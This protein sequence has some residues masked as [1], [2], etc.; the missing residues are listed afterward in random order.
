MFRVRF[1]G[2]GG[3]GMK[4]A[5]HILGSAFFHE[6]FEVQDAP[7]YGAERRGAP[8]FAYVRAARG[9]INERGIIRC[10]DLVIVADE[11]LV[12]V[13]AAEVLANF[14]PHTTLL[15]N[16]AESAETWRGRLNLSS[17]IICLPLA[18]AAEQAELPYMGVACAG[19]AARLTGVIGRDALEETIAG[20]LGHLG[21][22]V[23]AENLK[24]ALAAFDAMADHEGCVAEGEERLAATA[25]GADWIEMP[26]DSSEQATPAIHAGATSVEVRTGLW[27]VMRPV[28]HEDLCNKCVWICGSLCPDSVISVG[29]GG[30]PQVDYDHCKGCMICV[31]ACP[32]H[33]IEAVPEHGAAGETAATH[34]EASP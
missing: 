20:E 15:I 11:S 17:P 33:A 30:Y 22:E 21:K 24:R 13:P 19:A 28:V 1:H 29:E 32:R 34:E 27:R 12:P 3:Q 14:A 2:R 5:S 7:R 16:S 9:A 26:L 31:A 8:I 10:P 23:V 4:T 25:Q 18:E 6:G